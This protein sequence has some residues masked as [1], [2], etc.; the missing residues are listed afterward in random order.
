MLPISHDLQKHYA[1]AIQM[2]SKY[3]LMADKDS[4]L[5]QGHTTI[6]TFLCVLT[7]FGNISGR[8]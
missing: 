2:L 3:Y 1:N 7:T 6:T 5:I 4:L 8:L